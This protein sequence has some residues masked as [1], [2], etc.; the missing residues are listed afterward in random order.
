[1][2][3]VSI[4][5]WIQVSP[6]TILTTRLWQKWHYGPHSTSPDAGV[7]L[8]TTGCVTFWGYNTSWNYFPSLIISQTRS[9]LKSIHIYSPSFYFYLLEYLFLEAS[10]HLG[11]MTTQR[12]PC[13][14]KPKPCRDGGRGALGCQ[15]CECR[16]H[17]G[18]YLLKTPAALGD[19]M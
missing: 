4:P 2:R 7:D 12:P 3:S 14:E 9:S 10:C 13:H 16:C 6:M 19:A 1:M 15:T 18:R 8:V 5:P 11:S 17:L